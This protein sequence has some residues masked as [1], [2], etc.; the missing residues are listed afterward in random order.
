MLP[1]SEQNSSSRVSAAAAVH[2]TLQRG[3]L[4]Q[5]QG[6]F[7]D[8]EHAYLEVLK[9]VPN[10]SDALSLLGQLALQTGRMQHGVDLIGRATKL[11]P[12]SAPMHVALGSALRGLGRYDEALASYDHAIALEPGDATAYFNRGIALSV[13]A[14][15]IEALANYDQVIAL[16]PDFAAAYNNRGVALEGLKR[17]ADAIASYDRAI[18]LQPANVM[19]FFN[20]ANA[21]KALNRHDE[22]LADY[23]RAIALKPDYPEARNNRGLMLG[24]MKRYD[25]ALASYDGA[26]AL[27]PDYADAHNNRGVVLH[28]LK[29]PIEALA[30][31]DQAIVLKPDY[32]EAHNN[33]GIALNSLQRYDEALASYDRAIALKP[34]F[35]AAHNNRGNALKAL[36]R[37]E[38][39]LASYDRAIAL[40]PDFAD[41]HDRR[42]SVLQALDRQAEAVASYDRAIALDPDLEFALGE[43]LHVKMKTCDWRDWKPQTAQIVRKIDQG[44]RVCTP[45]AI[46]AVTESAAC[47]KKAAEIQVE[48]SFP[49]ND[50]LPSIAKRQRHEK[51]RIGYFS[52]DFRIHTVALGTAGLFE[53]HDKA[54]FEAIG[55]SLGPDQNDEMRRR[56]SAAFDRFIDVRDRSDEQVALLAREL[57][58]DIAVDLGGFT[59]GHRTGIF[60]LRAAPIQVNYWGYAGTIGAGYMDYL[61]ADRALIP[62]T[63]QKYYAERIVYLPNSYMPHDSKHTASDRLFDR[64]E[65]GLPEQGVVFC[66]FNNN[67]KITPEMFD[68]WMRI[69]KQTPGSVIWL[70]EGNATVP[71]NLRK[72]AELRGVAGERLVFAPLIS[73]ADHL[74]RYRLADLFLDTL[75]CNAHTTTGDVLWAGVPL[76]TQIGEAFPSRVAASGLNAIGLPELI[77]STRQAYEDLAIELATHPEK[78]ADLKRKLAENRLT[79]PLFD[80]PLYA[81]H[82]EAAYAAMYERYQAGLPPDHI[83]VPARQ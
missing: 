54:L 69:L 48:V 13:L 50:A 35:A 40:K 74:A 29:R 57:E 66:C 73:P 82:L 17:H 55:F 28:E 19:A 32:A 60:A 24:A 49:A 4:L 8:A 34:D 12:K 72:E 68:C 6:R 80:M 61:V 1:M 43:L 16:N 45:F 79:M 23:D 44:H 62:E 58:I 59:A 71:V 78:L 46:Q 75:P 81:K 64:S 18:A 83:H 26:I 53:T 70:L 76:L 30:S 37:H 22:A 10:H 5:N 38:E 36:W 2:A 20:R 3:L 27:K 25:E 41:A 65:V 21:L 42:G 7:A 47:Q 15:H 14:R 52:A 33:R 56:T 77:T 39:A 67:Y 31:C 11:N 63:H 51:I 9:Q